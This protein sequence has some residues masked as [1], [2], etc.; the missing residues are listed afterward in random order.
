MKNYFAPILFLAIVIAGCNQ[1]QINYDNDNKGLLIELPGQTV[2]HYNVKNSQLIPLETTNEALLG[3]IIKLMMDD[4]RFYILDQFIK[5]IYC[6]DLTGKFVGKIDR[7]GRGPFE[8][9][10]I[11]DFY[12]HDDKI[13][14]LTLARVIIFDKNTFAPIREI[15][16]DDIYGSSLFVSDQN[17]VISTNSH[18]STFFLN[19]VSKEDG[20]LHK[21]CLTS[22]TMT[23]NTALSLDLGSFMLNPVGNEK[24]WL[25]N[26]TFSNNICT[27]TDTGY[28]CSYTIDFGKYKIPDNILEKDV[29]EIKDYIFNWNNKYC[30]M[31]T[32]YLS[33]NVLAVRL[34]SHLSEENYYSY[35]IH[36]EG[37]T[38][39]YS[40]LMIDDPMLKIRILGTTPNGFVGC[41]DVWDMTESKT[42]LEGKIV[43]G[44]NPTPA[45]LAFLNHATEETNP[46]ILL[47]NI[48]L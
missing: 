42:Q 39:W 30:T 31:V 14:V 46:Y 29:Q 10:H 27:V 48:E 19:Y 13:Y 3:T 35:L 24:Q 5:C 2:D 25:F 28:V 17:I 41:V 1:T 40:S 36:S 47:F 22:R 44:Y 4:N 7:E 33:D 23:T 16:L 15:K 37:N 18:F 8:Y 38:F 26:S 9:R 11:N 20:T 6:F 32:A 34:Q 43:D 21:S 45:E 12:V